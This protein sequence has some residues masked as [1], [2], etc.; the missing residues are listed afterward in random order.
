MTE[1]EHNAATEAHDFFYIHSHMTDY[2]EEYEQANREYNE[3]A[4]RNRR[5][6]CNLPKEWIE[7]YILINFHENLI[8][9]G[10]E[11]IPE[12]CGAC[13]FLSFSPLRTGQWAT[14]C[15]LNLDVYSGDLYFGYQPWKPGWCP[16][17][18]K[19]GKGETT[20]ED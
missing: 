9:S 19:D 8:S 4:K 14:T 12:T 17:L 1:Q 16:L 2:W 20:I 6:V 13:P 15:D 3:F 18:R 5:M 7:K 10:K 11:C